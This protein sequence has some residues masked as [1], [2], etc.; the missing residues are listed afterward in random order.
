[1]R[2]WLLYL[3]MVTISTLLV[4]LIVIQVIWLRSAA[5]AEK[6]E[7]QMH[8]TRAL[9][10]TD[11]EL[12]DY[13]Y[14][15]EAHSKL[16]MN[17]GEG[18]YMVHQKWDSGGFSGPFDTV[19]M[20]IDESDFGP[21]RTGVVK[22]RTAHYKFPTSI[23]INLRFK[24][25]FGDSTDFY[26][27]QK[28]FYEKTESANIHDLTID[29]RAITAMFD[30]NYADSVIRKCLENEKIKGS[31]GFGFLAGK[32]NEI[33]YA[34]RVSDSGGLLSSPY[35]VH[36]FTDNKFIKPYSLAL[37][38]TDTP[39][40]YKVNSWLLISVVIVLLLTFSFY[41][42]VRLYI[43][44]TKLSEMKSDFINNLTHE[45]NT[46]MANISLAIETLNESGQVSSP[47]VNTILNIISSESERLR[48]NIER[49]LQVATM[50]K[51]NLHLHKDDF[52]IVSTIN[53]VIAA[54][55]LQC[56]QLGGSISFS[57]PERVMVYGDETHILNCVFN[58]L[59]NAIKYRRLAPLIVITL[60]E[61][62][63]WI[64]I[65]VADNGKGMSHETLRHIFEKF[66]RAHEGDTHDNKGFGLG[67]AYVQGIIEAHHG[68][69]EVTS[70]KDIGSKFIVHLPKTK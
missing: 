48:D 16:Y 30:M 22:K 37:V 43:R 42:F 6:R 54:Y 57:H 67:L 35:Y 62:N 19:N 59:D 44:Q 32:E 65:A 69:I 23:E 61:K 66:Y 4:M 2:K 53:T 41:A 12:K 11:Q 7:K 15:F 51:G 58:L 50:E 31:F 47:K 36:L 24:R 55:Q 38:F 39:G 45:F 56:E 20:Y 14:C 8:V 40:I 68:K 33:E 49:A 18:F 34:R 21:G 28:S 3:L 13:F 26:K 29:S 63:D 70:K 52:D 9:E 17:P 64:I 27:E 46:P 5:A 60:E 10:K 1:M 25:E